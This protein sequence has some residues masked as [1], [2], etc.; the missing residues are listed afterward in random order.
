MNPDPFLEDDVDSSPLV[1]GAAMP[2]THEEG[3]AFSLLSPHVSVEAFSMELYI[4][5]GLLKMP[6]HKTFCRF[7]SDILIVPKIY[8]VK[9]HDLIFRWYRSY[10]IW[11]KGVNEDNFN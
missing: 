6:H 4:H 9:Y 3:L 5:L 10:N 7:Y 11:L 8:I 2:A 1:E